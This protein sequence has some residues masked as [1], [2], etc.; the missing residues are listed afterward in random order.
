MSDG[1]NV[2]VSD[3]DGDIVRLELQGACGTC[4]SSTMTMK[5]GL[6]K[7]LKEGELRY[8]SSILR[9]DACDRVSRICTSLLVGTIESQDVGYSR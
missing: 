1:G 6:E 3:I 8:H 5:M 4:P 2:A 7:P 9:G